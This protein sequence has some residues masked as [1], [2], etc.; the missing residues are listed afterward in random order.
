MR[1]TD[2]EEKTQ[3]SFTSLRMTTLRVEDD[4]GWVWAAI[5]EGDARLL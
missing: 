5:L 4:G 3:W 1:M 2:R